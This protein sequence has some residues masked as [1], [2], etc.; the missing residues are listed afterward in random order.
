MDNLSYIKAY[1]YIKDANRILLATHDR[2]DGDAAASVCAMVEILELINKPY[3]V[4]CL[5]LPSV[6]YNFLPHWDKFKTQVNFSDFDLIIALDCGSVER[7]NLSKEILARNKNQIIIEIDHHPKIKD[8]ADL[9]IRM[10]EASSTTELIY[11]FIKTNNITINKNIATCILTG[12]L[13][14]TANFLYPATS[15]DTIHIASEM[16][17][18]GARLPKI[19]EFT[20]RNKS[21]NSMKT[22][23]LALA[24]LQIN[25][26]YN[27]GVTVLKLDQVSHLDEEELEGISGFLSNLHE[28]K[29]IML[30]REQKDGTI[31][32][33]LRSASPKIDIS[34]LA[35]ILGGG[36]HATASGFTIPGQLEKTETGWEIV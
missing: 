32:G 34:K 17:S 5:D 29:G 4:F 13:T 3:S 9:E 18:H 31:K 2:P 26:K 22:W 1:N 20:L 10:I 30:L 28:V 24:N 14:D 27:F 19:N 6:H 25:K 8:Y 23:G 35:Q 21:I 15:A 7:T 11:H 33:S 12:I 36:G 16:L